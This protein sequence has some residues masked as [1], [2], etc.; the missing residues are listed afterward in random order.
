MNMGIANR[1]ADVRIQRG[2][3][4]GNKSSCNIPEKLTSSP[5]ARADAKNPNPIQDGRRLVT[6]IHR[7][8]WD[9]RISRIIVRKCSG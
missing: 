5:P 6:S 9:T 4:V 3:V 1:L 2:T 7:I 8:G